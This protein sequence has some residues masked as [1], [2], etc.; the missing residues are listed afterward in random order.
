MDTNVF[1]PAGASPKGVKKAPVTIKGFFS[2][3]GIWG[4][5]VTTKNKYGV[6]TEIVSPPAPTG[7]DIKLA[8]TVFKAFVEG[9]DNMLRIESIEMLKHFQSYL[10]EQA[11]H[12]PKPATNTDG[13]FLALKKAAKQMA[14]TP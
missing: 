3:D 11:Q 10:Q 2:K 8:A 14:Y 5:D 7:E 9:S 13:L 6:Q 4:R 1:N 12:Q